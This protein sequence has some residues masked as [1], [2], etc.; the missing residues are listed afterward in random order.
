MRKAAWAALA[1][2]AFLGAVSAVTLD[3]VTNDDV[4]FNYQSADP[5]G[6]DMQSFGVV[7]FKLKFSGEIKIQKDFMGP[8][9]SGGL[10]VTLKCGPND[11]LS[12]TTKI[13]AG[14]D[15]FPKDFMYP[16]APQPE[17][18]ARTISTI[19]GGIPPIFPE[20]AYAKDT[21]LFAVLRYCGSCSDYKSNYDEATGVYTDPF[22][23]NNMY[24]NNECSITVGGGDGEYK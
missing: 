8:F 17:A 9:T 21:L 7:I 20:D 5:S 14:A 19:L 2:L 6:S 16:V 18:V 12:M 1:C 3:K 15:T 4:H 23:K 24:L 10:D 13:P 22:E 11:E